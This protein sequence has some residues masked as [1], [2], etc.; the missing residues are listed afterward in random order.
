MQDKFQ[1]LVICQSEIRLRSDVVQFFCCQLT[2]AVPAR[3]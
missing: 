2:N 3:P 1:V